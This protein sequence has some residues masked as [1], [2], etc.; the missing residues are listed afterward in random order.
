MIK[1][2]VSNVVH[3][4]TTGHCFYSGCGVTTGSGTY[5]CCW[6]SHLF[7]ILIIREEGKMAEE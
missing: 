6:C 2:R 1:N 5:I 4:I 7:K 3:S